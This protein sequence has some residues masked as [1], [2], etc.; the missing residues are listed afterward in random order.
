[1]EEERVVD[2]DGWEREFWHETHTNQ[3]H[4]LHTQTPIHTLRKKESKTRMIP[5][6]PFKYFSHYQII[7]VVVVVV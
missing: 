4:G 6:P 2:N 1:M 7:V 5:F 3:Q